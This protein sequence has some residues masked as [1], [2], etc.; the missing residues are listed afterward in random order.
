ML[1]CLTGHALAGAAVLVFH[2]GQCVLEDPQGLFLRQ[3][4][5]ADR[6][7]DRQHCGAVLRGG[8]NVEVFEPL[9]AR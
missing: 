9:T 3:V 1:G 7:L 6:H 4:D 8:A 5:P 2:Q